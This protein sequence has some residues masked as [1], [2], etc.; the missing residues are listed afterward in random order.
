[1]VDSS[2][3]TVENNKI[4]AVKI[5]SNIYIRKVIKTPMKDIITLIPENKTDFP[6]HEFNPSD[7][8]ILGRVIYLKSRL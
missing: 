5:K 7:I 6:N 2:Q 4:Y 1:M 8:T 3:V